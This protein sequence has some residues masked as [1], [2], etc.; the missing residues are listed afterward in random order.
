MIMLV[1]S[2]AKS[3]VDASRDEGM[4]LPALAVPAL[5][6][7]NPPELPLCVKTVPL[8]ASSPLGLG[9]VATGSL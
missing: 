1:N 4:I 3:A 5:R 6:N 7:T 9:K 2:S 8:L